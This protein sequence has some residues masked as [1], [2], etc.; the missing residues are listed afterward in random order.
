L[1][2]ST[3]ITDPTWES[4]RILP[5]A[6]RGSSKVRSWGQSPDKA[7]YRHGNNTFRKADRYRPKHKQISLTLLPYPS[8]MRQLCLAA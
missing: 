4:S 8:T 1:F 5:P 6:V 3:S 7:D 2:I